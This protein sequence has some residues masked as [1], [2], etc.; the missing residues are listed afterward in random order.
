M[1]GIRPSW[2]NGTIGRR[3]G[4]PGKHL[5]EKLTGY[6]LVKKLPSFFGT[7]MFIVVFTTASHLFLFRARSIQSM[8]PSHFLKTHLNIIFPS[9]PGSSKLSLSLTFPHQN[10]ECTSPLP[11]SAK[12]WG[13]DITPRNHKHEA[14]DSNSSRF[15]PAPSRWQSV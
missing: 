11:P 4:T 2:V 15:I 8:P 9:M 14:R 10:P 7:R 5:L 13:E 3:T 1:L 12:Y 6:Q